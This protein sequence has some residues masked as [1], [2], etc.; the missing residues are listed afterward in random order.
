MRPCH[1]GTVV[2]RT[3][4]AL[5]FAAFALTSSGCGEGWQ[6]F[7]PKAA[8]EVACEPDS[9]TA[10]D[11]D[12]DGNLDLAVNCYGGWE[13]ACWIDILLGDGRGSFER[14]DLIDTSQSI[15]VESGDFDGD[16]LDDLVYFTYDDGQ[17]GLGTHVLTSRGD[18]RF[19]ERKL[20][21]HDWSRPALGD[22]NEDG[23]PDI[24]A[25]WYSYFYDE[26]GL[27]L[28]LAPD[29]DEPI[30]LPSL[31]GDRAIGDVDGDGHLDLVGHQGVLR[32]DGAGGFSELIEVG[33]EVG[34]AYVSAIADVNGD[35]FGDRI[36]AD[37]E[38]ILV[39]LGGSD[40]Q[41]APGYT[42]AGGG[43]LGV[44][45]VDHDGHLDVLNGREDELTVRFGDGA[46]GF[47]ELT[48]IVTQRGGWYSLLD[49]DLDGD[50]AVDVVGIRGGSEWAVTILMGVP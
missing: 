42:Y 33:K 6:L 18:G 12:G 8:V 20:H 16:G 49:V 38:E 37:P 46:G 41:M 36:G 23:L 27:D 13:Q 7:R 43:S 24:I 34:V 2:M 17:G 31:G 48:R 32:G 39:S 47:A 9:P 1:G 26:G 44:A 21:T 4:L 10:G 35:G 29:F 45:D 19:D 15:W 22:V 28:L 11:F 25:G 40:A 30:A 5:G 14:V 3:V 50:G